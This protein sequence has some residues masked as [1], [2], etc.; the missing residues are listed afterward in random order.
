LATPDF[1]VVIPARNAAPT[2]ERAVASAAAQNPTSILLVDHASSDDTVKLARRAGGGRL[3]VRTAPAEATLG[4]VRQLGLD[5]VETEYGMWLDADDEL[6]PGRA[7]RLLGRL[8]AEGGDFAFDEV[9]LHD[10]TTGQR[11]RRLPIPTFI[12]ERQLVRL[13][14][15][16][17]LPGPGVPAFRTSAARAIGFDPALHG[18]E[19]VDLLLRAVAADRRILLVREAGYRQFA[20]PRTLSRDLTNQAQMVRAALAKHDPLDVEQRYR[21]AGYHPRTIA[22]GM[23][24]FLTLRGDYYAALTWIDRLPPGSRREFQRGT[25]LAALG[26]H[27]EAVAP[28]EAA[29]DEAGAPELCNNFGVVLAALNRTVEA[30]SLF[31]DALRQFPDYHDASVNMLSD[32]PSRLTMLPLRSEPARTDY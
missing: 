23:V 26:R 18:A 1:T 7:E 6:L 3:A 15:R 8:D 12:G 20:F 28:L 32:R 17:V 2:I 14:E 16:N 19:D 31:A 22:W 9:E 5:A 27:D 11:L 30:N 29:F 4:Q 10:G 21:R 24:A 25:L 13:F